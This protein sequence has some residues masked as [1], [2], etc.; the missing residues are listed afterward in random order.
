M[1]RG[2]RGVGGGGG[3]EDGLLGRGKGG[4]KEWKD[5]ACKAGAIMSRVKE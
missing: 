3:G 2:R 5:V 1:T 4:I